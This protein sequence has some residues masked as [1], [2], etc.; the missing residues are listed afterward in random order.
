MRFPGPDG[1]PDGNPEAIIVGGPLDGT[2]NVAT[3]LGNTYDDITGVVT[4]QCVSHLRMPHWSTN[5]HR[6]GFYYVLPFTA[7]KI[8]SS[9]D[10]SVPPSTIKPSE[11]K[12]VITIG[13]YNVS[14]RRRS[15]CALLIYL[16]K[17]ENMAPTSSHV[18]TVANHI[19]K[20]LNTPD[21]MFVQEI[22][23]DSGPTDDGVVSANLT[24][25]T[26]VNAI[27]KESGVL[28]SFID[29][30]PV[31]KQDGGEPGGNIRQAYL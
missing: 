14:L 7:P 24:L 15:S 26:L 5:A 21:V 9:P 27:Q 13:D 20:Y 25:T 4:F 6:F 23:D 19:A 22:Q 11:K 18:P 16:R 17:V 30:V 28:Y 10:F 3:A 12:H 29:I 31:D 1:I 8:I 2:K